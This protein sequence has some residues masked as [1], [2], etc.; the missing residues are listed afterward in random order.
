[1][2]C[3]SHCLS[4]KHSHVLIVI[5]WYPNQLWICFCCYS[6]FVILSIG[7]TVI[8]RASVEIFNLFSYFRLSAVDNHRN[9]PLLSHKSE[10]PEDGR[11]S[12]RS[13]C[14]SLDSV[15]EGANAAAEL[16]NVICDNGWSN[17]QNST[18]LTMGSVNIRDSS[19]MKTP[20]DHVNSRECQKVDALLKFV[21]NRE[22]MMMGTHFVDDDNELD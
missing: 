12:H 19:M 3:Y 13:S 15:S 21:N 17:L 6:V 7:F 4:S 10:L 5:W 2:E 1:M 22:S 16:H 9:G 18:E 8:V 11:R 20:L 14:S